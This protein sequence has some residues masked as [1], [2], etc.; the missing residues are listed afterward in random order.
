MCTDDL[1]LPY[2]RIMY[3][4]SAISS[5]AEYYFMENRSDLVQRSLGISWLDSRGERQ[6]TYYTL[7][8]LL[9]M[10]FDYTHHGWSFA[11]WSPCRRSDLVQ[12]C[13]GI[14]LLR[15]VSHPHIDREQAG[16]KSNIV[17]YPPL[18]QY[19]HSPEQKSWVSN[20]KRLTLYMTYNFWIFL[21][22]SSGG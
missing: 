1:D 20:R 21:S 9:F 4:K 13:L 7:G 16:C 6:N 14:S 11:P 2:A 22:W 10:K 8:C 12:R 3:L 19:M 18:L 15:L 17:H 5:S